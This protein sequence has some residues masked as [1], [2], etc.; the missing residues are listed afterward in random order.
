MNKVILIG[1]L[2]RDADYR[3]TANTTLARFTLAVDRRRKD[4][5]ADFPSCVAFGKT[6]DIVN[7]Y[8]HKGSRISIEG[9]LQTGSYQNRDGVTVYTTDVVCDSVELLESR[10]A[11]A[12]V[13]TTPP[14]RENGR[15][16]ENPEGRKQKPVQAV[17]DG[18]RAWDAPSGIDEELPFD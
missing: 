6:A 1:R 17:L 3:E 10:N 14:E 2:T 12:D 11:A 7:K 8:T 9:R 16:R 15:G 5:G 13:P 4:D 18:F